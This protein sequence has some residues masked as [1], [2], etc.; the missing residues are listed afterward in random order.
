MQN[1]QRL[2]LYK[3]KLVIFPCKANSQRTKKGDSTKDE[4]KAV[5]QQSVGALFPI[6]Q[7][8]KRVKV[9]SLVHPRL[10]LTRILALGAQDQ[11]Q[12]ARVRIQKQQ[13]TT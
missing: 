5:Q 4:V 1:V 13:F 10:L 3:S 7:D 12:R 8:A 2:K 11:R 6:V 9:C